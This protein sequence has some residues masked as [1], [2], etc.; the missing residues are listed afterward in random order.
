VRGSSI[1]KWTANTPAISSSFSKLSQAAPVAMHALRMIASG[2]LRLLNRRA[3]P[4]GWGVYAWRRL[5][6]MPHAPSWQYK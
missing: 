4:A 5:R 3:Q 2:Q 6:G 1:V